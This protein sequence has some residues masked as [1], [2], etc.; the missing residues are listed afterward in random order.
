MR[1]GGCRSRASL[2]FSVSQTVSVP[3]IEL[4]NNG[5]RTVQYSRDHVQVR[6]PASVVE[7]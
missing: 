4:V 3:W 5:E 6:D 2:L 1:V 7:S